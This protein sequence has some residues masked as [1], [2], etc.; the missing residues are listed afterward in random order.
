MSADTQPKL[1][2]NAIR[3]KSATVGIVGLG[4]VGLPLARAFIDAGFKTIGFDLDQ[5]KVARVVTLR[6]RI[7]L[8]GLQPRDT[9][10]GK[11]VAG[12]LPVE[13]LAVERDDAGTVAADDRLVPLVA[14]ADSQ[15]RRRDAEPV[16]RVHALLVGTPV[17]DRRLQAA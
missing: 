2:A 3:D 10:E 7:G 15:T 13:E 5:R 12:L 16:A 8:D 11:R 14:T 4:Y 9:E 6:R 17:S 1:L